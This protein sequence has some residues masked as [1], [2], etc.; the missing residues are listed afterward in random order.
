MSG[1]DLTD[2]LGH[3]DDVDLYRRLAAASHATRGDLLR[4]PISLA[5]G[6]DAN[7][8]MRPH[9]RVIGEAFATLERGEYDRLLVVTPPQVGKPVYVGSMILMG[10]G[11][12]K[13]IDEIEVGEEVITHTGRPRR[14]SAVHQQG[15]LPTVRIT[16]HGG[17]ITVAALDHPFLT[18]EGWVNAGDL[19]PGQALATVPRP[20]TRPAGELLPEEARLLGLFVGDGA[21][22]S[23]SGVG[24]F[25]CNITTFSPGVRESIDRCCEVLGFVANNSTARTARGRVNISGGARPWLVKHGLAHKTSWTKRVP[26][27]VFTSPPEVIAEFIAGYWDCDGVVSSRGKGRDGEMR[28]DVAVELYSVSLDLVKDVQHLLLRLGIRS[29]IRTKKGSYNDA[30]HISFRLMVIARDD[31][32]KF[33]KWIRL[34]NDKR[35]AALAGHL[36][37]RTDF[38]VQLAAD[39]IVSVEPHGEQECL[40]L[41]VEDDHTFTSD[42]LVVHNSTSVAEWGPFWWL[43][44]HPQDKIAV[45]S[46]SDDLALR[47]GKVIRDLVDEHGHEYGLHVKDGSG[48]AKDW[49]LATGGGVRSV[50]VGAGLTGFSV[51]LLVVD[52]PHKDRADAE[53]SRMRQA[54]H[55]WYSSTALKRLQPDRNAVVIILTRWHPDDL[56]GRRLAEEGRL[57][58][59]GRWKVVHLPAIADPKF[60]VDPLGRQPGDPLPH[61]KIRT[62]DRAAL[63]AWWHDMKRT[64]IVRDWHALGQG[65]PQPSEG[66]LV[67]GGRRRPLR[68]PGGGGVP[69]KIARAGVPP[70]GGPGPPGGGGGVGGWPPAGGGG[71]GGG[72]G[73]RPPPPRPGGRR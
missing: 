11:S 69:P 3:L 30:E 41:T 28:K 59:G 67:S 29:M 25:N 55:D 18:P 72:G 19:V 17:R 49:D 51:N 10:D 13:R 61:P 16:T 63:L 45:A 23:L 46:Y 33:Q 56:A 50:G 24:Q 12:R 48:A 36:L 64:S 44:K 52:D 47:R 53:S 2:Q 4:T 22:S 21:V 20:A 9:L 8:R 54:V 5:R 70:G 60:G 1:Q 37:P 27:A 32:A 7:F 6:L 38:D 43:A 65:D 40:C 68:A 71:R 42:D 15:K 31:V 34:T 35:A 73:A 39:A 26:P 14:V 66:A 58:E 57:E 62:R